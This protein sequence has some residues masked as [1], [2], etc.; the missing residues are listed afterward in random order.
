MNFLE[1]KLQIVHT[2]SAVN[3]PLEPCTFFPGII[4]DDLKALS[5]EG[6]PSIEQLQ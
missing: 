3:W 4:D 6:Y 2:T 1:S 5:P